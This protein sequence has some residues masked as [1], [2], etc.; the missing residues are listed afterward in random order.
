MCA[1]FGFDLL[2]LSIWYLGVWVGVVYYCCLL[3]LCCDWLLGDYGVY[4]WRCG[5]A[6]CLFVGLLRLWLLVRL[7]GFG[8][9]VASV[10]WVWS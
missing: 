7:L 9:A 3:W 8:V 10:M 6:W 4:G 5:F 1:L 2:L